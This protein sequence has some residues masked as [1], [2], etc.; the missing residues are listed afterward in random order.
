MKN[1]NLFLAFDRWIMCLGETIVIG[2]DL[3]TVVAD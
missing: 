2:F 1:L 3:T